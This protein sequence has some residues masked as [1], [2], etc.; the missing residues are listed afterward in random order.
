MNSMTKLLVTCILL[1]GTILMGVVLT[2]LGK[3]YNTA[4]FTIHKFLALG[5]LVLTFME[6]KAIVQAGG[7]SSMLIV[8]IVLLVVGIVGLFATGAMLSIGGFNVLLLR[9]IHIIT[10]IS[11]VAGFGLLVARFKL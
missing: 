10:M 11:L 6:I 5:F 3:P 1:L 7:F 8:C 9:S 2:K 4:L